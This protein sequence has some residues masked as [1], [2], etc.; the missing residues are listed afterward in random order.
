MK[1]LNGY[2][3]T[4]NW[5]LFCKQNPDL[6]NTN[7]S[8]MYFYLIELCNT[9]NWQL[10]LALPRQQTM[11]ILGIKSNR[12]FTKTFEDLVNWGLIKI[13]QKSINQ[14]SA[15]VISLN[16]AYAKKASA[17]HKLKPGQRTSTAPIIKQYK[18]YKQ[19]KQEYKEE[20]KIEEVVK[21][22]IQLPNLTDSNLFRKPIPPTKQQVWEIFLK[23]DGTK[24]M[25]KK[26]WENNESTG[27]FYKGSPIINFQNLVPG[28]V[29]AWKKN[30]L[31]NNPPP[32]IDPFPKPHIDEMILKYKP[33][34]P[35]PD[36]H[37]MEDIIKNLRLSSK[38]HQ[39]DQF[40]DRL[41]KIN[42][43]TN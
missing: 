10:K 19:Y 5:F 26:F 13:I 32:I 16:S 3:L 8:A 42:E 4:K 18:Q 36:D 7:H 24:E 15:T 20:N 37:K 29:E 1:K 33:R 11:I 39:E 31:K 40:Q 30:N 35:H 25:A 38:K 41:K 28:F 12:T 22:Q 34:E 9:L 6:I 43:G 27:W 2:D 17:T 23:N 21:Q 14:H